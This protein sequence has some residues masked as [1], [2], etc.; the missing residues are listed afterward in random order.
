M[1]LNKLDEASYISECVD[2]Q[3]HI[4]RLQ[5]RGS[6][7]PEERGVSLNIEYHKH[8]RLALYKNWTIESSM[9][10]SVATA[11]KFKLWTY[12]GVKKLHEMLAKMG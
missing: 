9:M 5:H 8:L 12:D 4:T 11:V 10:H 2:F 3:Q 6:S 7:A 1:L